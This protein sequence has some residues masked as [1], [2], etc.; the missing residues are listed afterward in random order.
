[1]TNGLSP[2]DATL[3]MRAMMDFRILDWWGYLNPSL[4]PDYLKDKESLE[5]HLKSQLFE[6]YPFLKMENGNIQTIEKS[7][8]DAFFYSEK[9]VNS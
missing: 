3:A 5:K 2:S 6:H 9:N 8:W 1:M 7:E 4:E